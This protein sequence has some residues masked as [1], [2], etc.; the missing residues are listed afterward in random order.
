MK[1]T[2]E[3]LFAGLDLAVFEQVADE[4]W[5]PVGKLPDWLT[6]P[7]GPLDLADHFPLLEL[8]FPDCEAVWSGEQ[9]RTQSDVWTEADPRHPGQELYVQALACGVG[10]RPFLALKTLPQSLF[11][12]QQ[13]AHD[14]DLEKLK[15]ERLSRELEIKR[16]E[17]ERATEAKSSFL[18]AMSHEIRTPLNAII[19]MADVLSET[20]LNSEQQKC[21]D[22]FQRNGV[23]LLNLIN[24][25]LDL[26]KVEAG[27]MELESTE[28]DLRDV[29]T[30]A[31]EVV[32]VRVR[33]KGLLINQMIAGDAPRYL[34]G[35]PNRLR[36]VLI[37][38]LGNSIKFTDH[39]GL[40]IRVEL[41]PAHASRDWLRFAISDT[42][43]GIPKEKVGTIFESFSQADASTTRKYGGTGLGLSISR[44]LVE[45][46]GGRIW[47]ESEVGQGSTFFF[48]AHLAVQE[49]QTER[50]PMPS[51]QVSAATLETSI[52]GLNI[53][54]VDDSADNRTL[55][56]AYLKNIGSTIDIAENGLIATQM[57]R[58]S[59]YDV[60]LMDVEMPV[61]DG[62]EA[63]REMRRIES[64]TGAIATPI[65]ALTAHAFADMAVQGYA[66][67][68]TSL[69][70]KPIRKSTLL[71][72]I[73]GQTASQPAVREPAPEPLAAAFVIHVE[74]GMEDVVP[75]Y[76][77]KR[78]AEVPIY[79]AALDGGEFDTVKQLA[80]KM[81]GTGTGY[82]APRLTELGS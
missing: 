72:A 47:V 30:A 8:F 65:F 82:G 69:L 81:K 78:R 39:G 40:Q 33:A 74:E 5:Q 46:M 66:A 44:Q 50:R 13:L 9:E 31:M 21:V 64:E 75:G 49:D 57:F 19:G 3:D 23:A 80:H 25:I 73:A 38:L 34:R 27:H 6:L 68:F 63:T 55:I 51:T 77:E 36:Q 28:F 52:S 4:R 67:G 58:S 15:V 24:D 60:I 20:P 29:V 18:A 71:E 7:A 41:D 61:M 70:T 42:G 35:D 16:R 1:T 11:T 79:R 48:T 53:L 22:I 43:I 76:V 56:L 26:S 45:L 37:N 62:Y 59:H 32:E 17:A 12:W 54:L 2:T 14:F 10:G